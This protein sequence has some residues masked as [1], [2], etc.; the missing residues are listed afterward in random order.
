V[1]EAVTDA[2][3]VVHAVRDGDSTI[4]DQVRSAVA[5]G[6]LAAVVTADRGLAARV[7]RLGATVLAP[8]WL[9]GRIERP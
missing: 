1:P 9:L 6:E 4:I 3:E 8:G 2:V 7:E 5:S